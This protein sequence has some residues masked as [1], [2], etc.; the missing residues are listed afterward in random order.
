M[1]CAARASLSFGR[2]SFR[3]FLARRM[4]NPWARE[5]ARTPERYI[6][7][8]TP[9]GFAREI[10]DRLSAGS[11]VLDLGCGEGRDSVYFAARGF[12]VTGLDV[13]PEALAKGR[14]LAEEREVQV[15]WLCRSMLDAPVAGRFDL[16]YSCGSVHHLR[17]PDRSRLFRRLR[18][19]SA[20]G[21]LH[22]HIVFTDR[23]IYREKGEEIDYF[24][25][26]ELPDFFGGWTILADE[27]V[28]ISCAQDG[29]RHAHSVERLVAERP[30]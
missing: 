22:A 19:L 13:S 25:R 9:S 7:G 14:R 4:Q 3:P 30:N 18:L 15:Q 10:A 27:D 20:P 17:R 6:W 21:G 12:E 11:R 26:G 8:K 23:M 24:T 2:S 5:Y 16:V 28:Q 29:V 1:R